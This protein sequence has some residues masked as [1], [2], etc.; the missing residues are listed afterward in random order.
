MLWP[1]SVIGGSGWVRALRLVEDEQKRLGG[2]PG[3]S[4]E[5]FLWKLGLPFEN[6]WNVLPE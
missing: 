1:T 6:C 2:T 3:Y 4:L 5:G